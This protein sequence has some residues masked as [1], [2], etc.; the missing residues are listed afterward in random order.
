MEYIY[1]KFKDNYITYN[2][3]KFLTKEDLIEM[4]IPI[5][6]RNRIIKFIEQLNTIDSSL[7]FEELKLF[8]EKYKKIISGHNTKKS[9]TETIYNNIK[10]SNYCGSKYDPEKN[11]RKNSFS[12]FSNI[13]YS[14]QINCNDSTSNIL[15]DIYTKKYAPD[16]NISNYMNLTRKEN[17]KKNHTKNNIS[18][19]TANTSTIFDYKNKTYINIPRRNNDQN[20]IKFKSDNSNQRI[21][22]KKNNIIPK[23]NI[24]INDK[25]NYNHSNLSQSLIN[26][27]EII[28]KEVEKYEY[29]YE[30][31]KNDTK[32]RYRNVINI[33]SKKNI[34]N[35]NNYNN[36]Y[37]RYKNLSHILKNGTGINVK[38]LENEKERNLTFELNK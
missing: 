1:N 22:L 19:S 15:E 10:H 5:G 7:T 25:Y 21:R 29:N 20:L 32:R 13:K 4:K 37:S 27:F 30:K 17:T 34:I 24:C 18:K 26:K 9:I 12:Y 16:N 23:K 38:D 6:P 35:K 28:N 11:E 31:L 3:L 8:L 14:T 33:L 2:D 36:Y